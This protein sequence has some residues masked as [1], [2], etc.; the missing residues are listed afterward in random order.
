MR[1]TPEREAEPAQIGVLESGPG[2]P[3]IVAAADE[4]VPT[5]KQLAWRRF[6]HH[7]LAI[8]SAIVLLALGLTVILANVISPFNFHEQIYR[9]TLQGPSAR[10]WFG[11]DNLGRDEFIRIM[12][13]GRISLLVG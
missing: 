11:T 7:K 13:G 10:H 1:R 4:R 9:D 6:Q 2:A 12:Y 3:G 5:T 8:G